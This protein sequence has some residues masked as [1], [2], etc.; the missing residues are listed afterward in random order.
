VQTQAIALRRKAMKSHDTVV[1]V[2]EDRNQ[3]QRAINELKRAGFSDDK[4]GLTARETGFAT[5]G[6]VE[7]TEEDTYAS[8]GATAGPGCCRRLAQPL[9]VERWRP[10]CQARPPVPRPPDWPAH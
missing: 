8:E 7:G 4:I 9:P 6:E 3:A 1:G 2:F 10:Y 5:A